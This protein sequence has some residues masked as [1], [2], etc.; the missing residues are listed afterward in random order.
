[1]VVNGFGVARGKLGAAGG[2]AKGR[3]E[4]EYSTWVWRNAYGGWGIG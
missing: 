3:A 2:K 4:N 1:M